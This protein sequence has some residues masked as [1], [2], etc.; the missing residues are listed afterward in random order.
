MFSSTTEYALRAA[1]FLSEVTE[2]YQSSQRI[3]QA[4]HVSVPYLSKVLQQLAEAGLVT[5]QRGPTGGFALS[6]PASAIRLL[7]IVQAVEPIQRI[8][9]CP[10]GLREHCG[11]LCPLHRALDNVARQVEA[12]LG[13]Q[14]LADVVTPPVVPLGLTVSGENLANGGPNGSAIANSNGNGLNGAPNNSNGKKPDAQGQ[15]STF[16]G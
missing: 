13:A 1:V 7:D 11:T 9:E 8:H 15:S 14:T 4:T 12:T 10:L 3:A 5:S 6:R 16:L 2:G